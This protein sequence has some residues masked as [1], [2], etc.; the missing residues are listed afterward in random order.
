MKIM[1]C[2]L[3]DGANVVGNGFS[4]ELTQLMLKGLTTNRY[5]IIEFG[6]AKGIGASNKGF[7]APLSDEEYL[8][9]AQPF[10]KKAEIGMFLNAKRYEAANI[11]LA[12]HYNLGFLRCGSDAGDAHLYLK[13]IKDIKGHGMKAYFSQ[14]KAYILSP[15]KLA[16][17]A[18]LLEDAGVDEITLM[19]SAGC[20]FPDQVSLSVEAM[21]NAVKVPIGFHCHANMGMCS[22]N[23][24]A[25]Y[26]SGADILD[27]G[28]LGMAR[29]AGNMPTEL[30]T[31]LMQTEGQ[32]DE[33]DFYG[34][35]HFLD[36]E[37]IPAMTQQGYKPSLLPKDLIL[38]YSGC[39]SAFVKTFTA[40]AA[41]AGVDL[42]Q[43]IVETSKLNRKNPSET[44]MREVAT[45]LA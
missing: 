24:L 40:V 33:L 34:L 35:L 28:L 9:L 39:H 25:A 43:L 38:G 26:R 3:R 12:A 23:A 36:Q 31:A 22:A 27:C 18:R 16:E 19:D 17:E 21:K 30:A 6:N 42:Y 1:D 29:S 2:T 4:A 15:N 41:D 20:M 13:Q 8:K 11:E 44:L 32:C 14:M 7:P 45:K 5:P 10:L 37:L